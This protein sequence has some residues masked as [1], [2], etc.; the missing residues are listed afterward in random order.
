MIL[1]ATGIMDIW[2]I[3]ILDIR[4]EIAQHRVSGVLKAHRTVAGR[5]YAAL[6]SVLETGFF[7]GFL[8]VVDPL[9][10]VRHPLRGRSR[11]DIVND[12]LERFDQFTPLPFL[13]VFRPR[14]KPPA[15][16]KFLV[17]DLLLVITVYGIIIRE[18]AGPGG[19]KS[20]LGIGTACEQDKERY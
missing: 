16:D 11:I 9:D 14:L 2:T 4:G 12:R 20:R 3:G 8:P 18:I 6:N 13:P 17:I 15:H 5:P 1:A 19:R 7:K 10:Q